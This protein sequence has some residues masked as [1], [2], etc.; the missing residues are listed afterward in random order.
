MSDVERT[1][2]MASGHCFNCRRCGHLAHDCPTQ[3]SIKTEP[4]DDAVLLSNS[5]IQYVDEDELEENF[6]YT[7]S[8]ELGCIDFPPACLF[9]DDGLD[10]LQANRTNRE[11]LIDSCRV[12]SLEVH[13]FHNVALNTLYGG[14]PITLIFWAEHLSEVLKHVNKNNTEP[15]RVDSPLTNDLNAETPHTQSQINWKNHCIINAPNDLF[16]LACREEQKE[17]RNGKESH[18]NTAHFVDVCSTPLNAREDTPEMVGNW[19]ELIME[20]DTDLE[21][22][23]LNASNTHHTLPNSIF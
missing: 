3:G 22:A 1:E 16:V 21:G 13:E 5:N 8:I 15:P 6:L 14:E 10:L 2:L 17:G 7:G 9:V 19:N 18:A 23:L 20:M 11:S 4:V 12:H